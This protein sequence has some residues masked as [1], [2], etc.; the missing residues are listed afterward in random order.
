MAFPPG[1]PFVSRQSEAASQAEPEP[2]PQVQVPEAPPTGEPAAA[3]ERAFPQEFPFVSRRSEA[4]AQP[5]EPEPQREGYGAEPAPAVEPA[6][7]E[8]AFP[9]GFPFVSRRSEAAAQ[10]E[11]EPQDWVPEPPPPAEPAAFQEQTVATEP[12]PLEPLNA[13]APAALLPAIAAAPEMVPATAPLPARWTP[14]P[15]TPV[16]AAATPTR[17]KRKVKRDALATAAWLRLDGVHGP[18]IKIELVDISIAGARFRAPRRLDVG[19]K[20]Q[21][22]VETGPFRWTTRLQVIHST[23]LSNDNGGA[24]IGCAFLRNELLRPWPAAA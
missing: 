8:R 14:A 18:P 24:S 15:R 7:Q 6:P 21:I 9:Q 19:D 11:P 16:P 10:P 17:E 23:P 3:Q 13:S 20:A 22:R 1:F 4:A 5:A 12:L 2:Q